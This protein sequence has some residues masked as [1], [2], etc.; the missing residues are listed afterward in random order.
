MGEIHIME[1][2]TLAELAES[3]GGKYDTL[4][5][6]ARR[7]FP[8]ETFHRDYILS[9]EQIRQLSASG[10]KRGRK[11]GGNKLAEKQIR[12][13]FIRVQ[14]ENNLNVSGNSGYSG[15]SEKEPEP[16]QQVA[17]PANWQR[18][19]LI[20]LLIAPTVASVENMYH[21]TR[22]LAGTAHS[23][24]LLTV[25][26]SISALGF[27]VA[28]RRSVL[29]MALALLLIGFES[30]CNLTRVYGGLLNVGT[31]NYG[32]PVQF[33]GL[34]MDIFGTGTHQTAVFLAAF[35]AFFIAAVQYA[36]VYELKK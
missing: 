32:L 4:Y 3:F 35:T 9:A 29:V 23:A 26:L 19:I 6:K 2:I 7:K 1:K 36:A 24:I 5:K 16:E 22:S 11:P 20:G 31:P 34:V 25:V 33:L 21:V 18:Y 10:G 17:K 13:E 28:S 15:Y 30:F 8:A 14:P 27:V 12:T